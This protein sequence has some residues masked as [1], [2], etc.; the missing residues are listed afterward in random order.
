MEL[1]GNSLLFISCGIKAKFGA[2]TYRSTFDRQR[3]QCN[4]TDWIDPQL[5]SEISGQQTQR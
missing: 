4:K 3:W 2:D 1:S 5:P